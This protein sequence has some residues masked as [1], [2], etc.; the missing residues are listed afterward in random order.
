MT[1]EVVI[2]ID[3]HGDV[4]VEGKGFAGAECVKLT[5]A[6]EEAVGTVEQRKLKPEYR[7][8]QPVVRKVGA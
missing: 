4:T 7:Q 3:E 5:E 2:E 1:Q 8:T 6:I